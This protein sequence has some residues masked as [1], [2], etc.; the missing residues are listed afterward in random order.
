MLFS[1]PT[2]SGM[3]RSSIMMLVMALIATAP[4]SMNIPLSISPEISYDPDEDSRSE[5]QPRTIFSS[6]VTVWRVSDNWMYDGYLDVADFVAGSGVTT[7][8]ETLEGTLDRT[9]EDVYVTDIE[10]NDTL[11][12][13]VVSVGEYD[14]GGPISIDGTNGC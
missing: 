7:D 13:R 14:S 11:V 8:V 6:D 1:K 5:V 10:D 2:S 9:V 4:V 12:Y 3:R